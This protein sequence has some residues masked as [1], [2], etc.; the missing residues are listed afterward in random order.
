MDVTKAS[1]PT[2]RPAISDYQDMVDFVRDMLAYRKKTE[3]SFSVLSAT[4]TL[5]KISPTLVSLILQRKRKITYDRI[6]EM[7]RLLNLNFQE[8]IYFRHWLLG[9]SAESVPESKAASR[10]KEVSHHILNDWLNVYVK[11]CFQMPRIQKNPQLIYQQLGALAP[12]PRIEKAL[13]FLL[14]EGHLRKTLDGKI[15]IETNLAVAVDSPVPV[16]KIR[17]FH[18]NALGIAKNALDLFPP[19]ERFAST[20]TIPLNE[21]SYGEVLEIVKEFAARLQNFAAHD[22]ETGERLYQFVLNLSPTGGKSE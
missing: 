14:R 22:E 4:Q 7:A 15:V 1:P 18:K 5:R 3:K 11:D 2:L 19:T 10:R 17:Q 9:E 12:R 16:K 20:M 8:K 6:E 13:D 21:K